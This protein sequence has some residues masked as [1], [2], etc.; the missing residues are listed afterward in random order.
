MIQYSI[1][2]HPEEY[3][4]APNSSLEP[5]S[6]CEIE[7]PEQYAASYEL[8][9]ID[10]LFDV[11]STNKDYRVRVSEKIQNPIHSDVYTATNTQENVSIRLNDWTKDPPDSEDKIYLFFKNPS[12]YANK[13]YTN[14]HVVLNLK[15][16]AQRSTG[17]VDTVS[18]G[19]TQTLQIINDNLSVLSHEVTWTYETSSTDITH[20]QTLARGVQTDTFAISSEDL[21]RLYQKYINSR[22]IVGS[23]LLKTKL[24]GTQIGDSYEIQSHLTIPD[25]AD[26]K[27]TVSATVN[28]QCSVAPQ[29]TYLRNR[30]N[31]TVTFNNGTAGK[32]GA[33]IANKHVDVINNNVVVF[34]EDISGS[35]ETFSNVNWPSGNNS[36]VITVTDTRGI[37][38]S[39]TNTVTLTEYSDPMIQNVS[40]SRYNPSEQKV[41]DEGPAIRTVIT[42][43]FDT[44]AGAAQ[45]NAYSVSIK[46]KGSSAQPV[47]QSGNTDTIIIGDDQSP[48]NT[49]STYEVIVTI[50]D[51][52]GVNTSYSTEIGT[53]VYTIYRMAGGKGVA[54][55]KAASMFG[56]EISSSWPF[57]THGQEIQKLIIDIAHPV[58][59]IIETLDS[60][61]DPNTELP[62]TYW[63]RIATRSIDA[64]VQYIWLRS[65]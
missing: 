65:Q 50:T 49:E 43:V 11:T 38:N 22:D 37:Q 28:S 9:S 46:Q 51:G 48:F 30:T 27:P 62:N 34:S 54:F 5:N 2:A 19:S 36:I 6:Y 32:Y 57:Y 10:L 4:F 24:D 56:V 20:I 52:Y 17:L 59:S 33:T 21:P 63:R 26:T 53:S 41:D 1:E 3:T 8:E 25:N 55:G 45:S 44:N 23:V 31:V 42:A 40:V 13:T 64:A 47:T 35:S 29:G 39:T 7:V 16:K 18:A 60:D 14:I 61:Y 58:M 12:K 15:E